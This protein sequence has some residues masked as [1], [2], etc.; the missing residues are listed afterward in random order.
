[1]RTG[2]L[3]AGT[4]ALCEHLDDF[5][6]PPFN[7]DVQRSLAESIQCAVEQPAPCRSLTHRVEH[8]LRDRWLRRFRCFPTGHSF[9]HTHSRFGF[10]IHAH[11]KT[12]NQHDIQTGI[13]DLCCREAVKCIHC[14]RKAKHTK[15]IMQCFQVD[16]L[17]PATS[18]TRM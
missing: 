13:S 8:F 10:D 3:Q 14:L 17:L 16:A 15:Y 12:E 2:S 6:I 5:R 9:W 7:G 4:H 1:M 18:K 11:H